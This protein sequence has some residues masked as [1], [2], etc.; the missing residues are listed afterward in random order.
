VVHVSHI[1]KT[2]DF[3]HLAITT[4]ADSVA[5]LV[6]RH[7]AEELTKITR[8]VKRQ[9]WNFPSEFSVDELEKY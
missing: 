1:F 3:S 4:K 9:T 7:T 5:C 2:Q 8:C 6:W